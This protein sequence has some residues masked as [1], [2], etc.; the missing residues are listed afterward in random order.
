M[1]MWRSVMGSP[2]R[3][4]TIDPRPFKLTKAQRRALTALGKPEPSAGAHVLAEFGPSL[5]ADPAYAQLLDSCALV[6]GM[7]PD[8]AR[9]ALLALDTPSRARRL[10]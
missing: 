5:W 4:T 2:C 8:Q 7:H 9:C 3:C 10:C 1:L 6:I